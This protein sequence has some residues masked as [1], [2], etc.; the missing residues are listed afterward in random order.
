MR[1]VATAAGVS[2]KTVSRVVNDE[3]GVSPELA[4]RV[5]RAV[6]ELGYYR[7]DRASN[8]R[9]AAQTTQTIGF[10]HVDVAN[11]FFSSVYRGL[12]DVARDRGF[13][14]LAGSCHGNPDREAELIA[15][16]VSRRVDGLVVVPS[17]A[18]VDIL[19][20]EVTRGTSVVCV[21]LSP[22]GLTTDVILTDHL[23][24]AKMATQHLI[25]HGHERIAFL[26]DDVELYSSAVLRRMGYLR[27][28]EAAGLPPDESLISTGLG[29]PQPAEHGPELAERSVR[30]LFNRPN[31]PTAIFTAQNFV[32]MAAVRALHQLGLQNTI[33][34]VGFDDIELADVVEP[35]ITVVPQDPRRLGQLAGERLFARLDGDSSPAE[36]HTLA[37]TLIERG[38]GEIAPR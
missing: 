8:L 23:L 2:F 38:S 19:T 3:A 36:L 4:D 37:P 9:S 5:R 26:G 22:E 20:S 17:P 27:A 16:F 33:A 12:E 14:V 1:D 15:T 35:G 32:T 34:Q 11:P 18:A 21:D 28:L 6:K 29:S 13:I 31:P 25:D 24:G 10:V 30:E 7:D